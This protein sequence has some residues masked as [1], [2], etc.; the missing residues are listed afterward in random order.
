MN[1]LACADLASTAQLCEGALT[2]H[3]SLGPS[4]TAALHRSAC[5]DRKISGPKETGCCLNVRSDD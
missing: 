1:A 5:A 3:V 2:N 4:T